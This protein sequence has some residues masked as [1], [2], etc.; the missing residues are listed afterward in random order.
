MS[1]HKRK[2]LIQIAE[3]IA[4]T[5][6]AV[7]I[8]IYAVLVLGLSDRTRVAAQTRDHLRRHVFEEQL[9]IARLKKYQASLP[10][11]KEQLELFEQKR[12]PSRRQ[13]F[14]RAARLIREV[15]Q[16]SGVDVSA[17][18]YKLHSDEKEPMERLGITVSAQGLYPSLVKFAHALETAG[19]FLVVREFNLR[20]SEGGTLALRMTADLY[21][22]R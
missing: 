17:V 7:D 10:E 2:A 6:L 18:G 14:S 3:R 1:K 20:Q 13:G 5:V 8:L 12:V 16:R 22:T 21:L 19:D 4:L 11:A 15:G 9:R